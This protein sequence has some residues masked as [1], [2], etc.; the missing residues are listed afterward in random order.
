MTHPMLQF[1]LSSNGDQWY[2]AR[3]NG[4]DTTTVVHEA[5]RASGGAVTSI[6]IEDFLR[7]NPEAPERQDF[8]RLVADLIG[9]ELDA[10]K[11]RK[12][13]QLIQLRDTTEEDAANALLGAKVQLPLT[14]PYEALEFFN[15]MVDVV[16]GQRAIEVEEDAHRIR[17][18]FGSTHG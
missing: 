16:T 13:V 8:V 12:G 18:G 6:S 17:P 14:T 1:S 7:V 2:L 11:A 9:N 3:G 4:P 5:N 15:C 10:Y